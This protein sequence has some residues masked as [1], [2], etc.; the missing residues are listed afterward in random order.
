MDKDA[1]AD[2][3]AAKRIELQVIQSPTWKSTIER[4][5]PEMKDFAMRAEAQPLAQVGQLQWLVS[6]KA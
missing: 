5:Q 1:N 4:L 3:P 6:Q 2:D